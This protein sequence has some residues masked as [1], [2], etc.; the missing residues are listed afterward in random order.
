MFQKKL[1]SLKRHSLAR[2][3]D[4]STNHSLRE[5]ETQIQRLVKLFESR[6]DGLC[7]VGVGLLS[8]I[9]E[10]LINLIVFHSLAHLNKHFQSIAL[11]V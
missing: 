10:N 7:F 6:H 5:E 1:T 2:T 8:C 4:K 11:K 3:Q 9:E